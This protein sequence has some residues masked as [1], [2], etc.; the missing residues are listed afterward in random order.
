MCI[1]PYTY[2]HSLLQLFF[3]L[4]S[5][6]QAGTPPNRRPNNFIWSFL[7]KWTLFRAKFFFVRH[8]PALCFSTVLFDSPLYVSALWQSSEA[9]AISLSHALLL[10]S[11][12]A[13]FF[14]APSFSALSLS[15]CFFP[16]SVSPPLPLF[17]SH[18]FC[19]KKDR[20]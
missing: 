12:R 9:V 10:I 20:W 18:S 4:L 14:P 11:F 1:S 8:S 19:F 5:N 17:F 13:L 2:K 16:F 7:I 15:F 6:V 3:K